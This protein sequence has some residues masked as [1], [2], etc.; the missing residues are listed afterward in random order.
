MRIETAENWNRKKRLC[1]HCATDILKEEEIRLLFPK[2]VQFPAT[3]R[4]IAFHYEC[5]REELQELS[6]EV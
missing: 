4:G 6:E 5:L 2:V 1:E 3:Y